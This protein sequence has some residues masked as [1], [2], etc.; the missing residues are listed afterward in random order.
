MF[1]DSDNK[2]V[3]NNDEQKIVS[4]REHRS[5]SSRSS[6]SS[7]SSSKTSLKRKIKKRKKLLLNFSL[8]LAL[9]IVIALLL[10]LAPGRKVDLSIA[11]PDTAPESQASSLNDTIGI[12]LPVF[13]DEVYLVGDA[14]VALYN[15]GEDIH[16][17]D[18]LAKYS[19][20][21]ERLDVG[22]PVR[23]SFEIDSLPANCSVSFAE[24]EVSDDASFA[25]CRIFELHDGYAV[26]VP[27]LKTGTDYHYR[28]NLSLSNGQE[29]SFQSTFKTAATPRILSIDGAVNVRDI[30]GWETT[31]GRKIKQGLLYRGSEL[32]G[33]V[34]TNNDISEKGQ[35]DMLTV[36]GI[37]TDLDLRDESV[38]ASDM[39]A[40]GANVRHEYF[41]APMYE[42]VFK[43][44]N[45]EKVRRIFAQLAREDN[46]P[47]YLHCTHGADRTGTICYL[48]E[49]L[50]GMSDEDI[51]REYELTALYY[52]SITRDLLVEFQE[53]LG[54]MNGNTTQEKVENY[55]L[56]V[57][58]T[59]QEMEDIR[60]IFLEE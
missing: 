7:K 17:P 43:P 18:L 53:Q 39:H 14:A 22:V 27:H 48:L 32:D 60:S 57:G 42:E 30:G 50:L 45:N 1:L 34:K 6:G 8:I 31:D 16:V 40:L 35:R 28:I 20:E 26:N 29:M 10:I 23:L 58:I 37:K 52:S 41:N 13:D 59:E 49:A 25:N 46:Y 5:G 4:D 51:V 38:N 12:K 56:S 47:I 2:K 21:G 33:A 15:A 3:N 11:A 55:L 24:V 44:Q 9:I 19:E 54:K 36:L